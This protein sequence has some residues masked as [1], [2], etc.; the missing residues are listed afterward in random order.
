MVSWIERLFGSDV[1]AS[2][3][4]RASAIARLRRFA[5]AGAARETD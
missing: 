5:S 4:A 3:W 1:S 2:V